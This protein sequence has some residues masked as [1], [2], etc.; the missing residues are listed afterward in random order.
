MYSRMPG[1]RWLD[2]RFFK[3]SRTTL[4]FD[5]YGNI[6][7]A[8]AFNNRIQKFLIN[9]HAGE[10]LTWIVTENACVF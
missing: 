1:F 9:N 8:D 2:F 10:F 4:W 5:S 3:R 6:F 7:V